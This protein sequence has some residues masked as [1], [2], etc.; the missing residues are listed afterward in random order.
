LTE[1]KLHETTT[2]VVFIGIANHYQSLPYPL[3]SGNHFWS[4]VLLQKKL[5]R[6]LVQHTTQA[7][8]WAWWC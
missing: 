2:S 1:V 8:G 5:N 4:Q 6:P 7:L 3:M